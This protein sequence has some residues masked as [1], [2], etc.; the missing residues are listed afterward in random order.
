MDS[1]KRLK[2]KVRKLIHDDFEDLN[3]FRIASEE[4]VRTVYD[5]TRVVEDD[6]NSFED[7]KDAV[8]QIG[9]AIHHMEAMLDQVEECYNELVETVSEAGLAKKSLH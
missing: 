3:W 5:F 6:T 9:Q 1:R 4:T 2:A 8:G 7:I